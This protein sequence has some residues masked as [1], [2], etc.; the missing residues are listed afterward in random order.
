MEYAP[1]IEPVHAGFDEKYGQLE[2]LHADFAQHVQTQISQIQQQ[3]IQF[4]QVQQQTVA[5]PPLPPP[6]PPHLLGNTFGQYD[7]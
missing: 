5:P 7:R 3:I 1:I 6:P 2:K 4:H